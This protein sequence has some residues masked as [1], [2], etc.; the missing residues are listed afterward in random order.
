MIV[1]HSKNNSGETM[2]VKMAYI[3]EDAKLHKWAV[4]LT[5]YTFVLI[6]N[7]ALTLPKLIVGGIGVQHQISSTISI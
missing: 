1:A 4:T 3:L 6:C 7:D 5:Y 2:Q